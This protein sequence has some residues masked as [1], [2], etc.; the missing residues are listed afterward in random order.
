MP[1]S[2][3]FLLL[4]GL[5]AVFTSIDSAEAGTVPIT[6]GSKLALTRD[7]GTVIFD[8]LAQSVSFTKNKYESTRENFQRSHGFPIPGTPELDLSR[9]PQKRAATIDL[10]P[11]SGAA[12]R[13]RSYT[14]LGGI[15]M[16]GL[17]LLIFPFFI[18]VVW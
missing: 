11:Q 14:F 6:K 10:S 4:A 5:A 16:L 17:S 12:C 18:S 8:N 15:S 7:D 2:T 1:S 13:L 9:R 3:R